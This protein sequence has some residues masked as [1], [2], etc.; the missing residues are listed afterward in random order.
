MI[1]LDSA[2]Y[3]QDSSETDSPKQ[4]NRAGW[5]GLTEVLFMR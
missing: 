3:R 1:Y 4:I 2:N 5:V